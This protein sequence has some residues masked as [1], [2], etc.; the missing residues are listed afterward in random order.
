MK[1]GA[2]L[3]DV[4]GS[5]FRRPVTE[6]YPFVKPKTAARFRGQ[7]A[8]QIEKCTGCGLCVKD[9]PANA[10]DLIVL[11]KKAKRF[12]LRYYVD[13]C[14]FCNQCAESCRF[15]SL[16]LSGQAWELAATTRAPF[17]IY[18]GAEGDIKIVLAGPSE[19]EPQPAAVPA[20]A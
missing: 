18:Y 4:A 3:S 8:W 5:L 17:T 16:E 1:F 2:M 14:T 13:R 9:C 6:L 7:L 12:V 20:A 11:D 10:L 19:A 15:D